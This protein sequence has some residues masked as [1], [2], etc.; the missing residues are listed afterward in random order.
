[1]KKSYHY[2]SQLSMKTTWVFGMGF[3]KKLCGSIECVYVTLEK[4]MLEVS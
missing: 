2:F 4:I 3:R 1:M